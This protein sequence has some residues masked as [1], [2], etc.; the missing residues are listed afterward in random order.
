[1]R[2]WHTGHLAIHV[3][4]TNS[5]CVHRKSSSLAPR[6]AEREGNKLREVHSRASSDSVRCSAKCT[7]DGELASGV[8]SI[9]QCP[10][11]QTCVS[12]WV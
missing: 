7:D 10:S 11:T 5:R 4:L 12:G 1:M 9:L 6:Q 3:R 2:T 8:A